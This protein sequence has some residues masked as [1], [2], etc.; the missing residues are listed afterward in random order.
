MSSDRLVKGNQSFTSKI[1]EQDPIFFEN[2][3]TGQSP[4]YFVI[5]CSDSRVSPSVIS[6]SPLG[7]MFVHRNIANQVRENDE[8]LTSSLY[9]ALAHLKVKKVIIKGHTECGG[10][11]AAKA[12]NEEPYL[13][14]WIGGIKEG[15]TNQGHSTEDDLNELVKANVKAQVE[16]MRQHPV[17][18]EY[19]K[20]TEVEGYLFHLGSGKLEKLDV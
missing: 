7:T 1:L 4:E 8:S 18:K 13:K 10:V 2:L 6:E 9:Y 20:D 15:F 3:K 16:Q 19:G 17:Y 11:A 14:S 12:G 5:S